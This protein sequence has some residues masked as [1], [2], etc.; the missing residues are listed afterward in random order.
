MKKRDCDAYFTV[1]A[2]YVVPIVFF[3][4]IL[5]IQYGFFCYEKSISIQCCYLAALRA[6]NEWEVSGKELEKCAIEEAEKLLKERNLYPT[7]REIKATVT[8]AG[9]EVETKGHMEVLFSEISGGLM[10]RWETN[11]KRKAGR[12]IPSEYIRKYRVIKDLG[13]ENDGDNQQK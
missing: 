4:I 5:M 2:A 10:D 9:L 8:V 1:E 13:G 3:L 6:S 7:T 11:A 12:I